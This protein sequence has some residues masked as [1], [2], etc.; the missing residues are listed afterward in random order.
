MSLKND[1]FPAIAELCQKSNFGKRLPNALYIHISA[2][3]CLDPLLQSYEGIARE[4]I[5][6]IDAV[7]LIKF[8]TDTPKLSYLFYPDFDTDPHPALVSSMVVNLETNQV[9]DRDY[10]DSLNPPILHRKETFVSPDYPYYLDFVHLTNLEVSLGLLENS[11]SIGTRQ[12]WEKRLT[13]KQ[14]TFEGH[15]LACPLRPQ[16]VPSIQVERHR[17]AIPRKT[18]S[19]P[20]RLALEAG[21][22][23]SGMTFFDYGC[24]YGRDITEIAQLGHDSR[25]WDPFYAPRT[26]LIEAAIVNLGYVINV[27]EDVKERREALVNAW[28]LTQQV[29]IVS[30][31]VL[32]DD[33]NRGVMAYG[34]GIITR[35]NTFQK[36]F[37]QEELKAYI[38]Q[39]LEVDAVPIG[40]GIYLVF[41]DREQAQTFQASRFRSR[42][43]T[44]TIRLPLKRFEDYERILIPLMDFYA[45]RGRLPI[46]G[47]LE[48]ENEAE[49]RRAFGNLSRAFQVVLQVTQQEEW[50]EIREQR[51]QELLLYLALSRFGHRPTARQLSAE[52]RQDIKDIFAGYEQAC[53]L[54]DMMLYSL[55]DLDKVGEACRSS[56]IGKKFKGSFVVHLDYVEKLPA[57]LRLYEGCASRTVGRLEGAN[58]VKFSLQEA[59]ISYLVYG[60]FDA[61]AH[62][63]L[64][65]RLDVYLGRLRVS[66]RDYREESNPPIVHEK[67]VL[68]GKDYPLYEKFAQLSQKERDRGLLDDYGPIR[69]LRG[70]E[71]CLGENCSLIKGHQLFWEKNGDVYQLKFLQSQAKARQKERLGRDSGG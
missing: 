35:R 36:Y 30:A 18:L 70:W 69:T 9:S 26:D 2:L 34:D 65:E 31:Q 47:E 52:M 50:D 42:A 56:E 21:V 55:R 44:P 10:S 66:Y 53:I 23:Q 1:D 41:R 38:D 62:P 3:E 24:G 6:N 60:H 64:Q 58:V 22:F 15:Y 13:Q 14:I 57:L 43:K 67:D 49:I 68:V 45:Q 25:G 32:I 8:S 54:A 29:L 63:L 16:N 12:Q 46:K 48:S 20:V 7:T 33:P 51:R 27:I 39:V 11:R 37:E 5:S 71:K 17:A 61:I 19:R 28:G 4:L 59:K 40:L